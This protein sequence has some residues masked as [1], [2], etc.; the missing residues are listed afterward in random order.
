[1]SESDR[2]AP[3]GWMAVCE[4]DEVFEGT[5]RRFELPGLPPIAVFNVAGSYHVTDDTCSHGSA[6]LAEGWL[7]GDE[8][9]CPFHQG[10]FCVRTGEA[11]TSPCELPIRVYRSKIDAGQVWIDPAAG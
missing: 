3:S 10:R 5:G 7:E 8:I 9:E 1:M 2:P 11:R 4:T 6:S